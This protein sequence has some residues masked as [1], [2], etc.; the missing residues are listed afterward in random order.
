MSST[1]DNLRKEK[2]SKCFNYLLNLDDKTNDTINND[3][4]KIKYEY[5]N[6]LDKGSFFKLSLLGIPVLS[7]DYGE[8]ANK[9]NRMNKCSF[10]VCY[11]Y[12]NIYD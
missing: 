6:C 1:K 8:S 2:E 7:V 12:T 3:N 5:K 4:I 10:D 9:L 11:K